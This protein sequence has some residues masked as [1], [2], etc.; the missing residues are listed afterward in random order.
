MKVEV[1]GAVFLKL[2]CSGL[3]AH[4]ADPRSAALSKRRD[5]PGRRF[6]GFSEFGEVGSVGVFGVSGSFGL[7]VRP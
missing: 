4:S 3:R 2:Q 5:V 7:L 1:C 6:Q